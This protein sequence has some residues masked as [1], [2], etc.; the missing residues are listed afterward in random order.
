[1]RRK[2]VSGSIFCQNVCFSRLAPRLLFFA[3]LSV[4]LLHSRFAQACAVCYGAADA[5]M[6]NG[7]NMGILTLLGTIGTVLLGFVTFFLFLLK[8]ARSASRR[9]QPMAVWA[10]PE[11]AK[12]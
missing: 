4:I 11:R 9:S 3:G 7:M 6:T 2:S 8:R 12:A 5:P 1:M 10:G